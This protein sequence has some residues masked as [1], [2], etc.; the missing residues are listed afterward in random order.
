MIENLKLSFKG[1]WSHKLRSLL[2]M[3][4]IIIGIAA[5]IAIVSAIQGTNE[6]LKEKLI[7]NGNNLVHVQIYSDSWT[8]TY[9]DYESAQGIYPV[10]DSMMEGIRAI[11]NVAAASS[12]N[13]RNENYIYYG[14]DQYAAG[15][16]GVYNDYFDTCG[17][18]VKKGRLF[19]EKDIKNH[20]N[21]CVIDATMANTIFGSKNP[22]GKIIEIKGV[23][24]TI[25]GVVVEQNPYEPSIES[26]E[27]YWNYFSNNSTTGII[28]LL[29]SD[30]ANFYNFDEA[31]NV[32]VKAASTNDMSAAG[33]A[34]ADYLN[35]YV[36]TSEQSGTTYKYKN[37]D[38][39]QDLKNQQEL[40]NE[41]NKMLV[42]IASISLL[43]G[44]IG[45]MN[46]MLVSV[47]ERTREVGLKIAIGAPKRKIRAQFLT[48][49]VALTSLG[50]VI[51]IIFGIVLAKVISN[52]MQTPFALSVPA[53]VVAVAFSMVIGVIFGLFPAV[54][55]SNLNP[56]DALRH[57]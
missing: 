56:I 24:S 10:T 8:F 17:Y 45:V 32:V 28:Y 5:I 31:Q 14:S 6:R 51:G 3:L 12:Y 7:G 42:W 25:V 2:T 47:T 50:G 53:M 35:N 43:V 39:L 1:I 40:S 16:Y 49:A 26:A 48:E 22:I 20:S 57:D 4:G 36:Q 9:S 44:G 19:N 46:I 15:V 30:W 41:T 52:V 13:Q 21:V 38:L 23:P 11:D 29:Q 54:K 34:V 37:E 27:D 33:K 55:A 18:L